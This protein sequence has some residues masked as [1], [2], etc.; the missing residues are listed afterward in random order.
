MS[1]MPAVAR[2]A[3]VGFDNEVEV[4][5]RQLKEAHQLARRVHVT[6]LGVKADAVDAFGPIR[7]KRT[8]DDLKGGIESARSQLDDLEAVLART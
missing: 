5:R 7:L 4:L 2:I 3:E 8:E 1:T 6:L